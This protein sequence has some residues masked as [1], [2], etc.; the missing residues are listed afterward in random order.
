MAVV[1]VVEVLATGGTI[2]SRR[3]DDG[4][5][6]ADDNGAALVDRAAHK[7]DVAVHSRDVF[8][9]NSFRLSLADMLAI[10]RA[11]DEALGRSQVAGVVVTHGTDT[12]EETAF[13]LD[14]LHDD[15]RPVIVTGAQRG[16]DESDSDGPRNLADAI[17]VAADPVARGRGVLIGFD[18]VLYPARGTRKVH[19]LRSAAFAAPD[20]GPVGHVWDGGFT[21][22]VLP[23]RREPLEIDNLDRVR[24]DIISYY[25]GADVTALQAVIDAGATGIVLEATGAGNADPA[26]AEKVAELSGGGGVVALSTRVHAGPVTAIYGDG[27][28]V[29]LFRAGA[30][31]VGTLRSA[32]A[33]VLLAVLL[34][35][36][37]DP[38]DVRRALRHQI[39][40]HDLNP[41]STTRG[42]RP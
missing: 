28:G 16:A 9:V 26:F 2:A 33:R 11:V 29:D 35:R 13:L 25:P 30:V 17:T 36:H 24:V 41:L 3:G 32:Q 23:L 27:G 10:S 22:A 18:G 7:S 31:G 38:A 8:A 19:T 20:G 39:A 21:P 15:D 42:S 37:D 40:P 34:A 4:A 14:L 6:R 5:V 12:M 1:A